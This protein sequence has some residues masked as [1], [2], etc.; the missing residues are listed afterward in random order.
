MS[1]LRFDHVIV[2]SM[3]RTCSNTIRN[4]LFDALSDMGVNVSHMHYGSRPRT[5][6]WRALSSPAP[7]NTD[8]VGVVSCS[9]EPVAQNLSYYWKFMAS[10]KPEWQSHTDAFYALES[11]WDQTR[12]WE[13]ELQDWWGI[14]P[15]G[16][17]SLA[18]PFTIVKEK[19]L[20]LRA[21]NID[22]LPE[23]VGAWLGLD[24][25]GRP[26]PHANHDGH[27]PPDR[28]AIP[29]TASFVHAMYFPN[30]PFRFPSSFYSEGEL[31]GLQHRWQ[32]PLIAG[33]V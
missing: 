7:Q 2:H 31:L 18:Q 10:R 29:I 25:T 23:A 22:R 4:F 27:A 28:P 5:K 19:L 1:N 9:R 24:L 17:G 3:P 11:H 21:E 26:V 14:D 30:Q 15:F 33:A 6:D 8:R 13:M 16:A 20:V 12:W 32:H